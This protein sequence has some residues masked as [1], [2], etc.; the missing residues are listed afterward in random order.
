[1]R[2]FFA[3]ALLGLAALALAAGPTSAWWPF[4]HC[5]CCVKLCAKQYNAFSPYCLDSLNGCLPPQG[6]MGNGACYLGTPQGCSA[7]AGVACLGEL[8][9]PGTADGATVHGS[10][11]PAANGSVM[12]GPITIQN[13]NPT[14]VAPG[15]NAQSWQWT[16]GLASPNGLAG[17]NPQPWLWTPGVAGQNGLPFPTANG[18]AQP[19]GLSR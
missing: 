5:K 3:S 9:A 10:S 2:K 14:I 16:P 1:M 7:Y 15:T 18:F 19:N 12:S 17:T 13:G 6:G 8:P 4:H 11:A